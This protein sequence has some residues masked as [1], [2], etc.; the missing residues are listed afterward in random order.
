MKITVFTYLMILAGLVLAQNN[1]GQVSGNNLQLINTFQLKDTTLKVAWREEVFDSKLKQTINSMVLNESYFS[2]VTEAE[3]AALGYLATFVG[4]EC[5]QDGENVKCKIL[6]ALNLGYQCSESNKEF[7]KKW[8]SNEPDVL[9]EIESCKSGLNISASTST[10]DKI[11]VT[12]KSDMIKIKYSAISANVKDNKL[13]QWTEE[14]T[15]SVSG[16][17]LDL[18]KRTKKKK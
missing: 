10:F 14:L 15:F 18:V 1:T 13:E 5:R 11:T 7:L 2:G 4:N 3:K 9:S 17:K 6:T 8:F 12:T 16:E